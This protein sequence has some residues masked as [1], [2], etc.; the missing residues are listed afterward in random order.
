MGEMESWSVMAFDYFK[1]L[2]EKPVHNWQTAT[3]HM[4]ISAY[5]LSLLM[6][7]ILS[8]KFTEF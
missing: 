1:D 5:L 7:Q 8:L 6:D 4:Q 3:D 2:K